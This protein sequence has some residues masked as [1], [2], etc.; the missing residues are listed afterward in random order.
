[1]ITTVSYKS[2]IGVYSFRNMKPCTSFG[3]AGSSSTFSSINI[4]SKVAQYMTIDEI[5]NDIHIALDTSDMLQ[6]AHVI[7]VRW[8][9]QKNRGIGTSLSV[10]TTLNRL[11]LQCHMDHI[12]QYT[13]ITHD[14]H[15]TSF[16]GKR[17]EG[18]HPLVSVLLRG[19]FLWAI[20][21]YDRYSFYCK[22][23]ALGYFSW[24]SC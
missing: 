1:M 24:L 15:W 14:S 7:M 2:Q 3:R 5:T 17:S 9:L 19:H 18:R 8:W 23:D 6:P 13:Y 16:V 21:L 10:T 12:T 22:V 4:T 11:W 20:T